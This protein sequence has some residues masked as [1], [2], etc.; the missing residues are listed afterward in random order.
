[1]NKSKYQTFLLTRILER[2]DFG[3]IKALVQA[4]ENAKAMP[5]AT[6]WQARKGAFNTI[7]TKAP[8]RKDVDTYCLSHADI[9]EFLEKEWNEFTTFSSMTRGKK[10]EEYTDAIARFWQVSN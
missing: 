5:E 9:P 4:I 3:S 2:N 7:A 10:G 8:M 6:L 1:M